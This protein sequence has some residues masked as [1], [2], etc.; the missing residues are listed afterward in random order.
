MSLGFKTEMVHVFHSSYLVQRITESEFFNIQPKPSFF[1]S[2][3][4]AIDEHSAKININIKTKAPFLGD[5]IQK[6]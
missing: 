4:L 1:K 3:R 2:K 5:D 6:Y